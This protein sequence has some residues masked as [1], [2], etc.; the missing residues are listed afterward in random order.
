MGHAAGDFIPGAIGEGRAFEAVLFPVGHAV[1]AFTAAVDHGADAGVIAL[2]ELDDI[3][4]HGD[5]TAHHR[6]A[7]HQRIDRRAPVAFVGV[8]VGVTDRAVH[9]LDHHV[10]RPG[11]AA[12]DG[13]E[14]KGT[15]GVESG[16]GLHLALGKGGLREDIG[17]LRLSSP[18][19]AGRGQRCCHSSG[20]TGGQK[21]TT[22]LAF[23]G[24]KFGGGVTRA[25]H[26]LFGILFS[27]EGKHMQI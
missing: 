8:N 11:G 17:V 12:R 16:P 20:G 6:V 22:A 13:V 3:C 26:D 10:F 21:A 25:T 9:D 5:H 2:A 27:K 19:K 14:G 15:V 4:D 7:R 1:G 24:Q 23:T 18:G